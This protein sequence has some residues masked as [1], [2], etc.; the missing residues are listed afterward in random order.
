MKNKGIDAIHFYIVHKFKWLPSVV[1]S[2]T[3]D[4]L[5]FVLSETMSGWTLPEEARNL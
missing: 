4:D 5:G 3:H 2:M 1:K